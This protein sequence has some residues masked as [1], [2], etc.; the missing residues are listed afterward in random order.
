M[1]DV[2]GDGIITRREFVLFFIN[3]FCSRSHFH[4]DENE[5]NSRKFS[6]NERQISEIYQN[7]DN[8]LTGIGGVKGSDTDTG[9]VKLKI[10]KEG[11]GGNELLKGS[12]TLVN[13]DMQLNY[14]DLNK[15]ITDEDAYQFLTFHFY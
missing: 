4:E 3:V 8:I 9:R 14:D 10:D 15:L 12:T 1:I 13:A 2:T 5:G 7:V 11:D 6:I